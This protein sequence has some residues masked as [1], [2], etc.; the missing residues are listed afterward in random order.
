M[1]IYDNQGDN[2]LYGKPARASVSFV[3]SG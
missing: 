2:S 3:E 1:S